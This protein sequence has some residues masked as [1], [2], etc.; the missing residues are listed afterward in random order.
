MP[1]HYATKWIVSGPDPRVKEFFLKHFTTDTDGQAFDFET[2]TPMPQPI[3]DTREDLGGGLS[4]M[5]TG[6]R[7][8]AHENW[9]T[10]WPA[11]NLRDLTHKNGELKFTIDTAWAPPEPII[12]KL[13]AMYPDLTFAVKGRDEFETSWSKVA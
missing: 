4:A 11:Y 9:G 13:Q 10:K 8:W 2:I 5:G 3:K 7:E 1:N 12:Q 6:E